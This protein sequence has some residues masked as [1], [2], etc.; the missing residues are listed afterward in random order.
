ME[1]KLTVLLLITVTALLHT[2]TAMPGSH[3]INCCTQVYN[4]INTRLLRRVIKF[5]IQGDQ[6]CDIKAVVLYTRLRTICADPDNAV[7]GMWLVKHIK[8]EI[9]SRR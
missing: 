7:L 8:K 9:H 2:V 5:E 4:K 3:A 6:I 1:Q